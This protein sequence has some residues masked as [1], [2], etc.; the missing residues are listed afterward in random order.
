MRT[1][2]GFMNYSK[3]LLTGLCSSTLLFA[4]GCTKEDSGDS[5]SSSGSSSTTTPS[6]FRTACGSVYKGQYTNPVSRKDATQAELSYMGP[7]LL[8]MK[9]TKGDK[10]VKIH[11]LGVPVESSKLQGSRSVITALVAE[12]DGYVYMAEP[13][14]SAPLENGQEGFVAHVFSAS[15]KSFSETLLR[16]GYAQPQL[17]V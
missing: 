15:G 10:L 1:R 4:V 3:L 2:K 12:G 5:G 16:R 13:D 7:N 6:S 17:D 14:C 9:T 11:G 8:S